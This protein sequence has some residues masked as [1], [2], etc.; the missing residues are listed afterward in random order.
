MK[1]IKNIVNYIYLLLGI[2]FLNSSVLQAQPK[3]I[4]DKLWDAAGGKSTWE[5]TKY[6]MF[7]VSGNNQ[8]SSI[9]GT[10]KF[11][12]D[13]QSGQVRFEGNWN[14]VPVVA[15]Y[16]VQN[17]KLTHVYDEEGK[18]IAIQDFKSLLPELIDQYQH[19]LKVLSLPVSM[20][21]S[22]LNNETESKIWNAEKLQKIVFQNF[23]GEKGCIYMNEESGLIKRLDLANKS[24][25][26]NGY[27]D[28]GNGL[29]LPTTF[30]ANT[31]SISYQKVASFTDMESAKFKEF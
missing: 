13:K 7:S 26:V 18:D 14:N 25:V 27:K 20:V 10:R 23:M 6:I 12:L 11:L 24:Y 15:L 9:S 2:I 8:H 21:S 17:Q 16:N 4:I 22:N 3:Q 19:D 29:I 28:I 1:E 31:D 30:K 5:E